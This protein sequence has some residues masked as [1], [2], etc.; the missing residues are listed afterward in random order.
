[1]ADTAQT[2]E[3][4]AEKTFDT[5][6]DF[7]ENRRA[8]R[9]QAANDAEDAPEE[10]TEEEVEA[11]TAPDSEELA[12]GDPPE[13]Q[14]DVE[15][16]DEDSDDVD[17][18]EVEEPAPVQPA[19]EPPQ[20]LKGEEREQFSKLTPEAQLIVARLAKNGEAVVTRK[21]QELTQTR[22][23]L[24]QRMQGVRDFVSETEAAKQQ[25]DGVVWEREYQ[26]CE[27]Q[28]DINNVNMH[29]ARA[30]GI[31]RK[32]KEANTALLIAERQEIAT[33]L[34]SVDHEIKELATKDDPIAKAFVDPKAGEQ[35][36][37][38]LQK[39]LLDSGLDQET[40]IWM[41]APARILAYKAMQ[42]DKANKKAAELPSKRTRTA[43]A[44]KVVK[45]TSKAAAGSSTSKRL[46]QLNAKSELTADEAIEHMRLTRS[47][48]K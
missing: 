26:L 25:Y 33:H 35:R 16:S 43:P 14:D 45:S 23:Q 17:E 32:L 38:D 1:M 28:E 20:H 9:E 12:E 30:E 46:Q 10:E 27:T 22:Q 7:I 31:E 4:P 15:A 48:R 34:Q 8:E 5:V 2:F 37:K 6:D 40:L 41:P 18:S 19:A 3:E 29:K 11:E 44:P 24:E 13:S 47:K 39:Y 36:Q 21:S 42:Y